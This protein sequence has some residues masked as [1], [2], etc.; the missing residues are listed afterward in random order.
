MPS[1]PDSVKGYG[2]DYIREAE[3]AYAPNN[4]YTVLSPNQD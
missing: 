2:D 4:D 1:L 3:K